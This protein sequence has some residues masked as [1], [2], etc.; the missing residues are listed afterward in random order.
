MRI[1]LSDGNLLDF[2]GVVPLKPCAAQRVATA[3][4]NSLEKDSALILSYP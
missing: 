1:S 2:G 4:M 3:R